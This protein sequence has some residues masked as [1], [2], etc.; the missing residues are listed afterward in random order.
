MRDRYSI[1][2]STLQQRFQTT[3]ATPGASGKERVNQIVEEISRLTLLETAD[4]IA[5]LK[6]TCNIRTLL[7]CRL[8]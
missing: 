1:P 8:N 3:A 4:L 7:N 2:Q 5:Q 6:V